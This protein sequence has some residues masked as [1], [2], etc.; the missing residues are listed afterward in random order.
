VNPVRTFLVTLACALAIFSAGL[1]LG[2]HP[3]DLPEGLRDVFVEDERALRAE[4]LDDIED[5]Y[6][7]KVDTDRLEQ[8]SL[9]A[10]VR[11]LRD[12]FSHYFTPNETKVFQESVSGEFSGVGMSVREHKRGLLVVG[13]FKG[14]PAQRAGIRAG[15]VIVGVNGESIAGQAT[16]LATAKIKGKPGTFVRL[17]VLAASTKKRRT[18]RLKRA[19]IEVPVA[20]GRLAERDGAK[21]AVVRL[22]SF[23]SGAHGAVRQQVD[24]LLD[25]GARGIVLDMRG[26][27]GGLLREAVLVS[28]VFV[29]NGEIVSTRGRKKATRRFEAE[30]KAISARVPVVVLVDR[31]SASA[32][33]IVTGALRDRKRATVVGQR[34]FGKGVF[35][36]VEPLSNGGALDLTVGSYYLPSGENISDKGIKPQVPARDVPRTRR[37]EALPVALDTLRAKVR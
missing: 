5:N 11:A 13:V 22:A 26:N 25:K 20:D 19:R 7:K 21:L 35:Q 23:T 37:D 8:A 18:V 17:T 29:E 34:T 10:I 12:R 28:S 4:I 36:E 27:G 15:D 31:G 32:S 24:R 16:D 33:E 9:K 14:T 3:G 1:W 30:G 6:Y 2:G